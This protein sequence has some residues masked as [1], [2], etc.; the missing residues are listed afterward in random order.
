[1][2]P[3]ARQYSEI[4]LLSMPFLILTNSISDLIR[5]GGSPRYSMLCMVAG[6]IVNTILAPVFIFGLDWGVFDAALATILGQ[7]LSFILALRYLRHFRTIELTK[8]CFR[9]KPRDNL[10]TLYMGI[11]EISGPTVGLVGRKTLG[12]N[13]YRRTKEH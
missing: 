12:S 6:A 1:M 5:A 9:L 10:R 4:V 2:V 13:A 3:F 11:C 8:A 7:I